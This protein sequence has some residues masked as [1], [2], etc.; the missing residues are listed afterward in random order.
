[1]IAVVVLAALCMFVQDVLAV[2]LTDAEARNHGWLAGALDSAAWLVA[3]TTTTITVTALQ[4]HDTS[5]KVLVVVTVSA[6]N[7]LGARTGVALGKRYVR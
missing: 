4:G 7:L 1:M 2:L 5:L 6:A 3:I